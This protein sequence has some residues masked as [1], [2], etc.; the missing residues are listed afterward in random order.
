MNE[1]DHNR[2]VFRE[3]CTGN[4]IALVHCHLRAETHPA[5]EVVSAVMSVVK[6]LSCGMCINWNKLQFLACAMVRVLQWLPGVWLPL[7]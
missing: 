7:E 6:G 3:S 2:V 4:V 5:D 1:S